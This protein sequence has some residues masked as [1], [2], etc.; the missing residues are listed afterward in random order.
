MIHEFKLF[1]IPV[2]YASEDRH[3]EK[4]KTKKDTFINHQLITGAT[5][6]EARDSF[7]RCYKYESTWNYNKII[8]FIELNY[9]NRCGDLKYHIYKTISKKNQYN[10]IFKLKFDEIYGPN[11]HDFIQNKNN[12]DILT[13]I[14]N[15]IKYIEKELFKNKCYIDLNAYYNIRKYINFEELR[16]DLDNINV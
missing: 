1:E 9:D 5:K 16:N 3:N 8:G 15:R 11:L 14:E 12:H 7:I 4:W 13:L 2:Y 6:T 10:H